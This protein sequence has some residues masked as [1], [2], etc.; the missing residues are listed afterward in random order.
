MGHVGLLSG[1]TL[2]LAAL[3]A[4]PAGGAPDTEWVRPCP[5]HIEGPGKLTIDDERDLRVGPV[6]W[7]GL[8][9]GPRVT[10]PYETPGRDPSVKSAIAVRAGGPVLLRIPP[11]ARGAI[12]MV[13]GAERDGTTPNVRRVSEG[14]VLVRVK[15]CAPSRRRFSDG[16]PIGPWTA[17]S[18]GFVMKKAGCY[19]VEVARRG[20]PF[21]RRMLGF[22]KRCQKS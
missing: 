10:R 1:I 4:A 19:P 17:F 2:G 3:A 6:V 22:G 20:K 11:E 15:P 8:A 9:S 21:K 13:Y 7:F 5:T 16:R 18:G 14:Q 12:S